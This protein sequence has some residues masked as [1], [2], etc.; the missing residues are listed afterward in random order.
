[1]SPMNMIMNYLIAESRSKYYNVTDKQKVQ[2]TA[3]L[4]G[5]ISQNTMVDYLIIENQ[6]KSLQTK[7]IEV[8]EVID[9]SDDS[10]NSNTDSNANG[11]VQNT[12][13]IKELNEKFEKLREIIEQ[14]A[15]QVTMVNNSL[16][17][18]KGKLMHLTDRITSNESQIKEISLRVTKLHAPLETTVA[19]V[20]PKTKRK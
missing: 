13:K 9:I 5:A 16:E 7:N 19:V 18:I 1:M 10:G 15:K 8:V 14:N 3:L 20:K 2:T 12:V 11:S 17:E 6:A 4:M